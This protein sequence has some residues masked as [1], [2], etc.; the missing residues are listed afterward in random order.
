MTA[1][2]SRIVIYRLGSLGDTIAALPCFHLIERAYPDAERIVLTN[3]PVSSKAAPLE[4]V[5]KAGGFIHRS[6]PYP[7]GVRTQ[8]DL[9]GWQRCF[10][11]KKRA[12]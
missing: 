1:P 9:L 6:I 3:V 7:L 12:R 4:A 2:A 10:D 8:Q 5:L 11:T